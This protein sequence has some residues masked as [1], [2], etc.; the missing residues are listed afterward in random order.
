MKIKISLFIDSKKEKT[1]IIKFIKNC[2][3]RENSQK[4]ILPLSG[5]IDSTTTF[6]LL[7]Q[8]LPLKNIIVVY[9]P[10]FDSDPFDAESMIKTINIPKGNFRI[11]P[12]K[13]PVDEFVK[14]LAINRPGDIFEKIRL[15]NVMARTRM[16]ILYDLA[17]R[18]KALVCGTEN[19]SEYYLGYFTRFGDEVADFAPLLHLYKTQV[20]QLA[21]YLGVPQKII[22]QPPTAGLWPGQTDEKEIG[23]PYEEADKVLSL[24][25]EQN[26][27]LSRIKNLGFKN[28]RKIIDMC[29][30]NRYKHETPYFI[31]S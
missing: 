24:Y 19:R 31:K 5:G 6:Y 17:K 14:L 3:K 4:V 12:I 11:V 29:L 22:D 21:I 25:F 23:F 28:A 20:Y 30:R 18:N 10:Y 16:V 26:Q 2:L 27:T 1:R 7:K 9:S 13:K 15:G 8:V